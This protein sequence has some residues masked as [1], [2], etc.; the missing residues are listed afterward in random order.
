MKTIPCHIIIS[1]SIRV[2]LF[3]TGHCCKF[4][5][6]WIM[7]R[8]CSYSIFPASSLG[9]CKSCQYISFFTSLYLVLIALV[10]LLQM[11]QQWLD[12]SPSDILV[13]SIFCSKHKLINYAS[14]WL[15]WVWYYTVVRLPQHYVSA[16]LTFCSLAKIRHFI[17]W[18]KS[19]WMK[20][21]C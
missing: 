15:V 7:A 3:S 9:F 4:L 5:R 11:I 17:V 1:T 2:L 6:T 18:Y 10:N 14:L 20:W 8:S 16:I 12:I 13:R 19:I 21:F